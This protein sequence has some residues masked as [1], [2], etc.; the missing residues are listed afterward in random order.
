MDYLTLKH[1]HVS[2]ALASGALFFLR[3]IWMMR[4][5]PLLQRRWV[6]TLPHLVD[7]TL[8]GSALTMVFWSGQYPFVQ[9]WLT[10]K[11]L[12]LL[13]YIALGSIALKRGRSKRIRST[14]WGTALLVFF[15]IGAVAVTK[16][17]TVFG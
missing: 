4:D 5:S 8:L 2:C 17:P 10:A 6:K 7:T 11:V 12:A 3:G 13:L 9:N 16:R 14:A 1:L 15:Y